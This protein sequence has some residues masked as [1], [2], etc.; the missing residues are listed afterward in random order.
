MKLT[1]VSKRYNLKNI[2]VSL[3]PHQQAIFAQMVLMEQT[4][5][6]NNIFI[7]SDPPGSGKTF[8]ILSAILAEKRLLGSTF[9]L[10]IIPD[11]IYKQWM[12]YISQFSNEL[13]VHS[14]MVYGSITDLYH[15]TS[16]LTSYDILLTTPAFYPIISQTMRHINKRFNRV[17][18]DEIDSISFFVKEIIPSKYIWLVSASAHLM[19]QDNAFKSILED[20]NNCIECDKSFIET[21]IQLPSVNYIQ[22]ICKNLNLNLLSSLVSNRELDSVYALDYSGFEFNFIEPANK[23]SNVNDLL[24]CL[25]KEYYSKINNLEEKISQSFDRLHE[26]NFYKLVYKHEQKVKKSITTH[27]FFTKEYLKQVVDLYKKGNPDPQEIHIF[28]KDHYIAFKNQFENVIIIDD[29]TKEKFTYELKEYQDFGKNIVSLM[30]QNKELENLAQQTVDNVQT[31][32]F[33]NQSEIKVIQTKIQMILDRVNETQC[34]ICW[35]DFDK[36]VEKIIM[37]CCQNTFCLE[38]IKELCLTSINCPKCRQGI[39]YEKIIIYKEMVVLEPVLELPEPEPEPP[40]PEV[41]AIFL[42]KDKNFKKVLDS[43]TTQ[44]NYNLLIFSDYSGSF[45]FVR[46]HLQDNQILFS[47]LDGNIKN[48]NKVIENYKNNDIRILMIDSMHYGAGLNLENT[49]DVILMHATDR[50]EQIVGRAQRIGRQGSLNVHELLYD[51]ESE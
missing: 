8:S 33:T 11:N 41:E 43:I 36:D 22:Y 29:E 44:N 5:K 34:P 51:G 45:N 32:I 48:M 19:S 18:L 15:N 25:F 35:Q 30:L 37:N 47:E 12:D 31:S 4:M 38:C 39:D 46:K 10:I 28:F 6:N 3:F 21:S 26:S 42:D 27:S 24:S 50:K 49:T 2:N 14:F 16:L 9:N 40:L 17:V 20:P 23:I 7:L 13:N 1:S